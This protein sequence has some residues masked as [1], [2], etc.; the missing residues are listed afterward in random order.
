MSTGIVVIA[1]LIISCTSN[2][3]FGR[4]AP[5]WIAPVCSGLSDFDLRGHI[6]YSKIFYEARKVMQK[7]KK[8]CAGGARLPYPTFRTT[9]PCGFQRLPIP[10]SRAV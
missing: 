3:V 9:V 5:P 4:R 10:W 1:V 8:G 2:I 6:A 7:A